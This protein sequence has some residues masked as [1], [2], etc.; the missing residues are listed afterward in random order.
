[1]KEVIEGTYVAPAG[2]T[3]FIETLE[4]GATIEGTREKKD[5]NVLSGDRNRKKFRLSGKNVSASVPVECKAS[6]VIGAKPKYAEMFE[7]AGFKA[8]EY[9][10]R[11]TSGTSNTTS[12]INIANT[13]SL[14]VGD[15]VLVKES[16]LSANPDHIS[17]IASIVDDTSITLLIAADNAFTDNVELEKSCHLKLDKTV[18]ETLSVTKIYEGDETEMRAVGCRTS[19]IA[20]NNFVTDE[21]PSWAFDLVGL[22]FEEVLNSTAFSPSY[23]DSAPP[24]VLSACI[25]K[26]SSKITINEFSLAIQNNVSIKKSTCSANGNVSSRGT[27]KYIVSGSMNPYKKSDAIDFKLDESEFSLF[28]F[29]YNP[30][31]NDGE[32]KEVFAFYIPKCKLITKTDGDIEGIM[33]DSLGWEATPDSEADSI[34]IAFF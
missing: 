12:V 32:K 1:M 9:G 2:D 15:I 14:S 3:D 6:D 33:V 7:A 30:S 18:N 25:Y 11:I 19:N 26:D 8:R 28:G 24:L 4:D 20:L 27:G 13:S 5:R 16:E 23:E 29:A 22:N 21:Y 31:A 17:P 10:A 34:R